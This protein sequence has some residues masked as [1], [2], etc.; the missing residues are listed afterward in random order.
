MENNND[1]VATAIKRNII[2]G[3]V[4]KGLSKNE[5]ATRAGIPTS[6]FHRKL[7]GTGDFTIRELGQI[8]EALDRQLVDLLPSELLNRRAA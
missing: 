7:K 8:A 6:T 2:Y 4:D 3:L 1:A 5:T